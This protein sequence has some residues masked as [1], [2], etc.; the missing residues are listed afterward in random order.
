MIIEGTNY[1]KRLY[2]RKSDDLTIFSS[3]RR[4]RNMFGYLSSIN[5]P[6]FNFRRLHKQ[7]G[8]QAVCPPSCIN[9]LIFIVVPKHRAPMNSG[10]DPTRESISS[11]AEIFL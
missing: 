4:L 6:H 10:F 3:N 2:F 5:E 11:P 9:L 7:G 8:K 1:I